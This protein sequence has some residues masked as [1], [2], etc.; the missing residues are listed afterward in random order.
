[1]ACASAGAVLASAGGCKYS[2]EVRNATQ[3]PVSVLL[4]QQNVD[5]WEWLI[6]SDRIPPGKVVTLGPSNAFFS[7][8]MLELDA[9]D[10]DAFGTRTKLRPG[11]SSFDVRES[12]E[13]NAIVFQLVARPNNRPQRRD[14][15]PV[16]GDEGGGPRTGEQATDSGAAVTPP[17]PAP[18]RVEPT[19]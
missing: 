8:V 5:G 6:D 16:Q 14:V 7:T 19:R 11:R 15:A 17:P 18:A 10:E 4:M 12:I 13:G 9:T 3:R 2:V 1:M